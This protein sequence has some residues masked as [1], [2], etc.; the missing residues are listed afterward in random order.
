MAAEVTWPV[1]EREPLDGDRAWS[2]TFD[3]YD[4]R[5]D[6]VYYA[7]R[8]FA[9]PTE[10]AAFT[11]T[12][13]MEVAPDIN[14]WMTPDFVPAVKAALAELAATGKTNTTHVAYVLR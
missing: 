9:G 10:V 4:Q 7:I 6:V 5:N 3:S 12:V 2:A 8:L 1:F 13:G 14:N 11:V